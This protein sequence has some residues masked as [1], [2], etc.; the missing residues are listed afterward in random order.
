MPLIPVA[1]MQKRK[2]EKKND[3]SEA[4]LID[5]KERRDI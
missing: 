1:M 2:Q 4:V 3:Q 5:K